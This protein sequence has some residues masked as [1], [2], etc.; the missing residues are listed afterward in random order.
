MLQAQPY[1]SAASQ[2]EPV[3]GFF[4][5]TPDVVYTPTTS[6]LDS[7][8]ERASSPPPLASHA[9][10]IQRGTPHPE[11]G[12]QAQPPGMQPVPGTGEVPRPQPQPAHT[13]QGGT[14]CPPLSR[15]T[16]EITDNAHPSQHQHHQQDQG[17][18]SDKH[19]LQAL[20]HQQQQMLAWATLQAPA[21]A[22]YQAVPQPL[23]PRIGES[24]PSLHVYPISRSA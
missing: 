15:E 4:C 22:A 8:I 7:L 13:P 2:Q 6:Y 5:P 11:P 19:L 16:M 24:F 3:E 10:A 17:L 20:I 14:S 12:F 18:L 21:I 23:G 9:A 1:A